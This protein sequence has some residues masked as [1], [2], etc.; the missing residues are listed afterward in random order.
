[1]LL[2]QLFRKS[3]RRV[4]K[5]AKL[6]LAIEQIKGKILR[7]EIRKSSNKSKCELSFPWW[8]KIV[9]YLMS[10]IFASISVFFI[11][12]KGISFGNDKSTKWLTSVVISLVSSL[13]ITQPIQVFIAKNS[14][15]E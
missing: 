15:L 8:C 9:A 12:I 6:K 11:V 5:S 7:G 10:L 1:M 3:R 13:F 14:N 2:I 4:T